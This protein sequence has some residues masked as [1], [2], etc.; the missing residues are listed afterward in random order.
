[1][2]NLADAAEHLS[3]TLWAELSSRLVEFRKFHYTYR[4]PILAKVT[5]SFLDP[6]I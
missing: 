3:T 5:M 4:Q 6:I 2:I 1:V